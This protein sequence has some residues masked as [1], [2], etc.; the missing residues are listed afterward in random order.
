MAVF[1]VLQPVAYRIYPRLKR[2]DRRRWKQ[3][4]NVPALECAGLLLW[5]L[6]V[7]DDPWHG[8]IGLC[9]LAAGGVF[10]VAGRFANR[11]GESNNAPFGRRKFS[12]SRG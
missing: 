2:S 10:A 4:P 9:L 1:L 12:A 11:P 3:A 6:A 8:F 7:V 5:F